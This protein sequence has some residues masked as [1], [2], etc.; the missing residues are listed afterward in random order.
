MAVLADGRLASGGDDDKVKLW[1]RDGAGEPMVLS[2]GSSIKS[3]AVLPDGR[4]ASGG[5]TARSNF[6]PGRAWGSRWFSARRPGHV[7]G[8][9]GGWT[10]GQRR[11]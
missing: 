10:A 1:P 11:R 4:L 9:A 5:A 3:L 6:G 8:G 2:H 7:A